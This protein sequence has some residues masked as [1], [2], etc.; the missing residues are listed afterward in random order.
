[1]QV[2]PVIGEIEEMLNHLKRWREEKGCSAHTKNVLQ[3]KPLNHFHHCN[4]HSLREDIHGTKRMFHQKDVRSN[5]N[6]WHQHC[7]AIYLD[8]WNKALHWHL[9]DRMY[10][11]CATYRPV[12]CTAFLNI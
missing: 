5:S 4:M 1:M 3:L 8:P 12:C 9:V 6:D 2:S 10:L 11:V 7:T